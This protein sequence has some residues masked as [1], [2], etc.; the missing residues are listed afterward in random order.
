MPGRRPGIGFG[1]E[2]NSGEIITA[3]E[4]TVIPEMSKLEMA[5][6]ILDEVVKLRAR[7][8]T[9]KVNA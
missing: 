8:Q 2:R 1:S 6:R 5:G 3:D 4:A 7:Q 9:P